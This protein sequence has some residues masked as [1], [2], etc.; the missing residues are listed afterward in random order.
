MSHLQWY[1][2]RENLLELALFLGEVGL[3]VDDF[4]L[5]LEKPWNYQKEYEFMNK[6][7]DWKNYSEE[8]MFTLQD[9]IIEGS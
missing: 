5:F 1:D 9:Q 6:H 3:E 7:P 2:K 8:D 4:L